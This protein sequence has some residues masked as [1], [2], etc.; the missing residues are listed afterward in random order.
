MNFVFD[1][2]LI[3]TI[4]SSSAILALFLYVFFWRKLSLAYKYALWQKE[5][6]EIEV[7]TH[8]ALYSQQNSDFPEYP[9]VTIIVPSRNEGAALEYLLPKLLT[10]N[11]AGKFEVI[12]VDQLSTDE[13]KDIVMRLQTTYS[14]LRYMVLPSTMRYITKRKLAITLGVKASYG[15]W[16]LI[17][18]PTTTPNSKRWLQRYAENFSESVDFVQAYYNYEDN[19]TLRCRFRLLERIYDFNRKLNAFEQNCILG[20]ATANF[21]VRKNWFL[22]EQGFVDS[23]KLPF[24]EES[25]FAYYHGNAERTLLLCSPDTRL[26]EQLPDAA[27]L[28]NAGVVYS[29]VLHHFGK[30][31]M[32]VRAQS[33]LYSLIF[34]FWVITNILYVVFRIYQTIRFHSYS[35]DFVCPDIIYLVSNLLSL[36]GFRYNIRKSFVALG[37]TKIPLMYI[38][39]HQIVLPWRRLSIKIIRLYERKTF[40]RKYI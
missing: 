31:G 11:Y 24:G 32:K 21:A 10:Q 33:A 27:S 6:Q 2:L 34:Y 22:D 40:V 35:L 38:L 37:E 25:I 3:L 29:E 18:N 5:A 8:T 28:K 1:N 13:T 9:F 39:A 26:Y 4:S 23:L 36:Y 14:N 17:L 12:V 20:C 7:A 19:G 30:D 16:C 15:E